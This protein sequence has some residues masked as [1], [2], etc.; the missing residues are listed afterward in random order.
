ML[1]M[2]D[3]VS[4]AERVYQVQSFQV[5]NRGLR[6]ITVEAM[7]HGYQAIRVHVVA[8]AVLPEGVPVLVLVPRLSAFR[9]LWGN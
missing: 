2:Y 8:R 3:S 4:S 5:L 1:C 6:S 9:I 7:V